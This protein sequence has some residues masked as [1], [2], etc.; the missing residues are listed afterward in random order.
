M[1]RFD[2]LNNRP[3]PAER[4]TIEPFQVPINNSSFIDMIRKSQ[5]KIEYYM[6]QDSETH[7]DYINC[8]VTPPKTLKHITVSI[9]LK[10]QEVDKRTRFEILKD[11]E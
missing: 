1:T 5:A 6:E 3:V 10:T 7:V 11:L 9:K 4:F 8:W 2:I